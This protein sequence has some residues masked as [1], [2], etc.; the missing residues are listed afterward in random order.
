MLIGMLFMLV[1]PK[2][3]AM[4]PV[5]HAARNLSCR[6]CGAQP[7]VSRMPRATGRVAHP[8]RNLS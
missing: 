4:V 1:P 5:A 6:E 2:A 3:G 7:V 8:A